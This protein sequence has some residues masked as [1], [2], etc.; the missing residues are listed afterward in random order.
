VVTQL[1]PAEIGWLWLNV[2]L[3]SLFVRPVPA[4]GS[5]SC[6]ILLHVLFIP[7]GKSRGLGLILVAVRVAQLGRNEGPQLSPLAHAQQHLCQTCQGFTIRRNGSN[8]KWYAFWRVE[9]YNVLRMQIHAEVPHFS[10]FSTQ[11][12]LQRKML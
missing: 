8:E 5:A 2:L 3:Q 12:S 1:P 6:Y 11:S 7:G 4:S 10:S 9:I